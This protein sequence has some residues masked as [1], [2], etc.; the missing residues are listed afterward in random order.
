MMAGTNFT[1]SFASS[2][3]ATTHCLAPLWCYQRLNTSHRSTPP[4]VPPG[5]FKLRPQHSPQETSLIYAIKCIILFGNAQALSMVV[6]A[7]WRP[8]MA[9]ANITR[10]NSFIIRNFFASSTILARRLTDIPT[11]EDFEAMTVAAIGGDG[12]N[13]ATN[14]I[15]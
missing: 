15:C 10:I 11:T 13:R 3:Q 1:L 14:G 4:C 8:L 9:H 2:F 7:A 5:S 6:A 12:E